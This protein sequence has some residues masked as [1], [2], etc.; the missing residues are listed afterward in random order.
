MIIISISYLDFVGKPLEHII[1]R[2]CVRVA[3]IFDDLV[4]Y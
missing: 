2:S 1:L 4:N 3:S